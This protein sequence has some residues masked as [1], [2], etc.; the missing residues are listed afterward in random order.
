MGTN[1]YRIPK[2]KEMMKR[3]Q[4]LHDRVSRMD[5]HDTSLIGNGFTYIEDKNSDNEW[6]NSIN[7]WVEFTKGTHI[8]LGKRSGGWKFI[9]NWNDSKHYKTKE[10]LFKFIRDGRVVNEYG[11]QM[12]VEEFI[13]MTLEWGKEDGWDLETYYKHHPEK[14]T[15]WGGE[16]HEEYI[17][18]LRVSTS[19]EFF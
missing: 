9:W 2:S 4:R 13:T 5:W 6:D 7:P 17:D 19:T 18:G 16:K 12:D 10:Q 3:H 11:E 15:L 1:Y 14:R 8:H